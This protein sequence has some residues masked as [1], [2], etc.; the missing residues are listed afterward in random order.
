MSKKE[1]TIRYCLQTASLNDINI[2]PQKQMEKLGCEI[3]KYEGVS[4]GDCI[5]MKVKNLPQELPNYIELSDYPFAQSIYEAGL[6]RVKETLPP[7]NQKFLPKTF[8]K[9]IDKLP[10]CMSH[11]TSGVYAQVEYTY[12]HAYGGGDVKSYSLLVRKTNKT[13]SSSAWYK[14]NQLTQVTHKKILK[15]LKEEDAETK[16]QGQELTYYWFDELNKVN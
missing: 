3:V 2:H 4:M 10:E 15:K 7:K 11:F 12:S 9:I 5:F 8:V 14:E 1:I 13:W 16:I 6:E